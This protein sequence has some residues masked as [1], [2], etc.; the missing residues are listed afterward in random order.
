[1][2]NAATWQSHR[3][4]Q[5]HSERKGDRLHKSAT[6]AK[7]QK[8]RKGCCPWV[9][10][11]EPTAS[12]SRLES[13]RRE[14]QR[15]TSIIEDGP[16]DSRPSLCIVNSDRRHD[17][18]GTRMRGD[19][20]QDDRPRYQTTLAE[21]LV[22]RGPHPQKAPGDETSTSKPKTPGA[23]ER[24]AGGAVVAFAEGTMRRGSRGTYR[25][26]SARAAT[27]QPT[28]FRQESDELTAD[29]T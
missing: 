17:H 9:T 3:R 4:K 13:K 27:R 5:K 23:I 22:H 21:N 25:H 20:Q 15:E 2:V 8:T 18:V 26:P 11:V 10:C 28:H 14:V 29:A 12:K 16:V 1:M 6:R 24:A 7:L 19:D